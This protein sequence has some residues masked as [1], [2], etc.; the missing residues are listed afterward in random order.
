MTLNSDCPNFYNEPFCLNK[1]FYCLSII[2]IDTIVTVNDI[3]CRIDIE[4]FKNNLKKQKIL[5]YI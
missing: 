5:G 3:H 4:R 2:K 1:E